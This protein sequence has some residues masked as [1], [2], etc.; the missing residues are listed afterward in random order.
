MSENREMPWDKGRQP[1]LLDGSLSEEE[2][3]A[4]QDVREREEAL[5]ELLDDVPRKG[6]RAFDFVTSSLAEYKLLG[7]IYTFQMKT[8]PNPKLHGK[9]V[10]KGLFMTQGE[11]GD[12]LNLKQP[13]VARAVKGLKDKG[14]I[15]ID[16]DGIYTV[17][18]PA[19]KRV[20]E[21]NG[22]LSKRKSK[23]SD[24]EK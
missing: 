17:N 3:K 12:N 4:V 18:M 19:V 24:G 21:Q 16:G 22:W 13:A 20:A 6:L 2:K 14:L 5:A 23:K 9:E 7:L 10:S 8:G 11:I 1:S 15:V